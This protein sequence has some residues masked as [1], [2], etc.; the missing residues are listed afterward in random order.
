MDFELAAV[1]DA[2]DRL[3]EA[4]VAPADD[5]EAS[6][7]EAPFEVDQEERESDLDLMRI[8]T[9]RGARKGS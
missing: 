9:A 6:N 3:P 7:M 8:L 2:W 5:R 1:I 4:M